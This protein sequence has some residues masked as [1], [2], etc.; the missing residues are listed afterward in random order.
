MKQNGM[1]GNETERHGMNRKNEM[2][3][4]NEPVDVCACI[5][6]AGLPVVETVGWLPE[7]YSAGCIL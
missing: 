2:N 7:T 5:I 3:E 6:Y 1:E 4:I